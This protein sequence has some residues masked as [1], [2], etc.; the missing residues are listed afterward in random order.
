MIDWNTTGIKAKGVSLSFTVGYLN[1]LLL[2][3]V[4]NIVIYY[5]RGHRKWTKMADY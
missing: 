5:Y 2:Y 4:V 3:Y 1:I